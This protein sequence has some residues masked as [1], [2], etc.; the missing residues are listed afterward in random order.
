MDEASR[1]QRAKE[2]GFDTP[3]VHWSRHGVDVNELDSGK[4]ALAP[5]D[6]IGSHTGTPEAAMK[7]FEDR[8][9]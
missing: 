1:M 8:E 5:F 4:F 2:M 9:P 6:A 3:A 7:R